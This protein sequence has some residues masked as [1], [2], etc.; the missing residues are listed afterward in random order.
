MAEHKLK[1]IVIGCKTDTEDKL[2]TSN[3]TDSSHVY[4]K[5]TQLKEAQ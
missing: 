1:N 5:L 3:R 4:P 2:S